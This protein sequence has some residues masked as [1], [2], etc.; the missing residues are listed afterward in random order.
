M[1]KATAGVISLF[2]FLSLSA[3]QGVKNLQQLLIN[4]KADTTRINLMN[5]IAGSYA[6][7]RPD[8]TFKYGHDALALSGKANYTIG[9]VEAIRNI[10]IAFLGT[11]DFSK[12]LEYA[13][14]AL[15][16]SEA[17]GEK[18]LIAACLIAIGVVYSAQGDHQLALPY[19]LK[20]NAIYEDL[21]TDV[22]LAGSLLNTGNAYYNLNRLDSGRI[23]LNRSLEISLRMK[24]DVNVG[25]VYLNLGLIHSKMKEYDLAMAYYKQAIPAFVADNNHLFLYST[26]YFLSL[27]FDSTRHYDSALY[28]S[29]LS[30]AHINMM[31][32][33]VHLA[34]IT[35][36]LSSLFKKRGLLDSAFIYQGMAISAKDSL[37]SR[38]KEMKIKTLTF[39]EQLRQMQIAEQKSRD[40]AARRRT[41]EL[42][43]IAI[44]IPLFFFFVLLLAR[45][46][47][48]PRTVEF[49]GVLCLLFVFEF[50]VLFVH[51]YI[52]HWTHES[53]VWMLLILV[54]IATVL[55]PLHHRSEIWMKNKLT[56]KP[57]P[58]LT[59]SSGEELEN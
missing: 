40:A 53:P 50:V 4:A 52:G 38:E 34:E 22:D 31:S 17:L 16:R 43:A 21:N 2:L 32:S 20:A 49:L 1:K 5:R 15:K 13:L 25:A 58:A 30:L 37:T 59:E 55:V 57:K 9:K 28:Y 41:L 11:G 12:A 54:A 3:Q 6:E 39:N 27:S 35:K 14:D 18:K 36:Q 46:K 26:Y 8:L 47:V 44:F 7:S 19:S 45:K 33:P 23:F 10:G 48:K 51:P 56:Y 24:D 29:R 42:A